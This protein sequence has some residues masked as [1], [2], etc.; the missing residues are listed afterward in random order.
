[1][2][3]SVLLQFSCKK[4]ENA[5]QMEPISSPTTASINKSFWFN[6]S[7]GF[8]CGGTKNETGFVYSTKDGGKTWDTSLELKGVSLYDIYFF[9]D[10]LGYCC[11]DNVTLYKTI[12]K[13]I[14]WSKVDLTSH[15]DDFYKGTL[16]RIVPAKN[17]F[18]IVGGQF[19]SVGLIIAFQDQIIK[20]GFMGTSN[21]LRAAFAFNDTNFV[22]CGYG[23]AYRSKNNLSTYTPLKLADDFFTDCV[24]LNSTGGYACGY[25]GGIYKITGNGNEVTKLKDHNR[26]YKTRDNYTGMFFKNENEGWVIG[27][28]GTLL[29]TNNGSDFK[30]LNTSQSSNFLSIVSNKNN[31][32]I[33]STSDGKLIKIAQ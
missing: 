22:C 24:T 28:K 13:G 18:V 29:Y 26:N 15:Y 23:T 10:T 16:R 27:N 32:L 4:N 14:T 8:I 25:N 11:G 17:S 1:M 3:F 12:N 30:E 20:S 7:E 31:E 6:A 21:E 9:N 2:A 19:Y 5:I 33:I